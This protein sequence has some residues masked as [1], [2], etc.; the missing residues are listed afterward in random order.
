MKHV[1]SLGF[2]V[3]L[4]T[5][6]AMAAIH[7]EAVSYQDGDAQLEGYLAYDD[8]VQ[9]P[10]PL[11]L[12]VHEWKGLGDYAKRRAE[13]LAGLGYAAFAVDMYGKGVFAK[14]HEE[15]GKL[16]GMYRNV[17]ALTRRRILAG[18]NAV[19]GLDVVDASRVAAVGYCFGG[20]AALELARSGADVRGVV[21]FHGALDT[22]SP[23][24]AGT[25]K[26]KILVLHGADD[27]FVTQD[28]VAAFEKEMREA[29]AESRVIQYPGA[30]HSFTVAEAGNDPSTGVAYNAEADH[31]SWEE[32]RT[33]LSGIFQ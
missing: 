4:W 17:R 13:Q 19:R 5:S 27:R 28:I 8:A 30:V 32:M 3:L 14:D 10:R 2:G 26:A 18:L 9:G 29:G 33:F 21:T 22:P 23:A 25:I 1:V 31:Q 16:S 20:M 11:V 24:P 6:Q 7:T 15:A 12:V